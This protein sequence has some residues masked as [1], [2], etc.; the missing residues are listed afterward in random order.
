MMTAIAVSLLAVAGF[1]LALWRGRVVTVAGDAMKGTM[2]GLSA[3]T[4]S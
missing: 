3:M 1:G 2:A 4:D